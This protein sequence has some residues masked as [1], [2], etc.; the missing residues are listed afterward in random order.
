MLFVARHDV[1]DPILWK[2]TDVDLTRLHGEL[3][4]IIPPLPYNVEKGIHN[5]I[6][7]VMDDDEYKVRYGAKFPKTTRP[8]VYDKDI[9][10][11]ATN[12]A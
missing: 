3:T 10:N 2:P 9:S 7:L 12:V 1:F 4:L 11:N 5:L 8:V 6:G